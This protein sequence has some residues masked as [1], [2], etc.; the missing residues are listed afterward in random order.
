MSCD[1]FPVITEISEDMPKGDVYK[2]K[3]LEGF[4]E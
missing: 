4:I 1:H 2:R 3:G